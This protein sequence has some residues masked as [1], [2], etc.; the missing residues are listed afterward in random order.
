MSSSRPGEILPYFL[1]KL[2][3][4]RVSI[5]GKPF[6]SYRGKLYPAHLNE[7]NA[8]SFIREKALVYCRGK[9]IDVGASEW[10]LPGVVRRCGRS[11][12]PT[13]LRPG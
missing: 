7:G 12:S 1:G 11:A 4:R 8:Q 5:A 10:P 2:K 9:G 3:T 13:A 6:Y